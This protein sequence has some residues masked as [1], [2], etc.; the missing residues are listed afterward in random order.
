MRYT[1]RSKRRR[2]MDEA[3]A[4]THDENG[5]IN[6]AGVAMAIEF[7]RSIADGSTR[8]DMVECY[9]G[10]QLGRLLKFLVA[11]PADAKFWSNK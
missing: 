7:A 6:E 11:S 10:S 8:A 5:D 1:V 2:Q 4:N 9:R 3:I